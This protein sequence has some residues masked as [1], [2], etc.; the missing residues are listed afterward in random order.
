MSLPVPGLRSVRVEDLLHA[1]P[2][3][4][5]AVRR[6]R[7]L[8]GGGFLPPFLRGRIGGHPGHVGLKVI[9]P[10]FEIREEV[11][12]PGLDLFKIDR[13]VADVA[14]FDHLEHSGPGGRMELL[15]IGDLFRLEADDHPIALNGRARLPRVLGGEQN[16]AYKDERKQKAIAQSFHIQLVLLDKSEFS[17]EADWPG[18]ARE[19]EEGGN[20]INYR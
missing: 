13:I 18:M 4:L 7:V 19:R 6:D 2:P 20:W 16:G 5:R 8:A 15:V 12:L 11:V 1:A 14:L 10:V 17:S 3:L 9:P